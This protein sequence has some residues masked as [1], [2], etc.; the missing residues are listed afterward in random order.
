MEYWSIGVM[1]L[2]SVRFRWTV[3]STA[4]RVWITGLL[5]LSAG[6]AFAGDEEARTF[7]WG[8][9]ASRQP[10]VHGDMR[11]KFLGPFFEFASSTNGMEFRA[12]RPLHSKVYDPV[13]RR[14]THDILWPI[15]MAKR[16]DTE[17]RWRFL[18]T[19]Y[20]DFDVN[21]PVSRYRFM[22]LPIYF[23]G[24]DKDKRRYAA[25]FPRGGRIHEFL[26]RD[27]SEFL[28]FPLLAR[29]S[30]NEVETKD[31]LWPIYS[32]TEGK[33]IYRFRIFPFY[34]RS[35][36]R[37]KFEKRFILWPFWTWARYKEP[38]HSGTGYILWPLWGHVEL[39]DQETWMFVPPL[40]RFSKGQRLDYSHYPWPF[41]QHSRGLVEKLYIWPLWGEKHMHGY[42]RSFALWPIVHN[43]R[44][45]RGKTMARTF[46]V[47]PFYLS[48]SSVE[49]EKDE[50]G[51][52]EVLGKYRK[53]WPLFSYRREGSESCFRTLELW[54][55]RTPAPM[56]RLYAP[57]WTLYSRTG[58]GE[59]MDHELLWGLYRQRRRGGDVFSSALF[60]LWEWR[61]DDREKETR[62]WNLLKGLVGYSRKGTQKQVRV[63]YF[64]RFGRKEKSP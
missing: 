24:R 10:D 6:L 7:D 57:L 53:V 11:T 28:L 12:F 64:L 50:A 5:L 13:A 38:G 26:T 14:E 59:N 22:S 46:L 8:F 15:A 30:I 63:L 51:D 61:R 42:Y 49:K 39:E 31:V 52:R 18:L 62:E 40:F 21:D 1:L 3:E 47:V 45:D 17:F 33:G 43:M 41:I 25:I 58:I 19:Y 37:D 29:S 48:S 20:H 34:A 32:R 60:P 44:V 55:L 23:Q 27:E 56:E 16:H 2:R 35:H 36:H 4:M 54:P 9:I